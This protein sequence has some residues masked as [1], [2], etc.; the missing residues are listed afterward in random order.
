[1]SDD[2]KPA[3]GPGRPLLPGQS[4][5][6]AG[7][8]KT[9]PAV[10]AFLQEKSLAVAQSLFERIESNGLDDKDHVAACV[11]FLR[12]SVAPPQPE[13]SGGG[14]NVLDRLA[15]LLTP[16]KSDPTQ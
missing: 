2:A 12:F 3:R 15:A 9:P 8:P 7:T 5:N 11:A 10:R 6:P 14:D 13:K 16:N 1:M 4:G